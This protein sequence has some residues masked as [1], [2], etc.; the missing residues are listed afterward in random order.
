MSLLKDIVTYFTTNG[1]VT[2]E[3]VDAFMDFIPEMPD[4]IVS[5]TEYKGSPPV[6]YEELVHRSVQVL[7]RNKNADAARLKAWELYKLLKTEDE[8]GVV[9]FTSER[10]GQ[11]SLRQT[12]FR[13]DTDSSERVS[14]AFNMGVT[15]TID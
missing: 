13:V 3:G 15:T 7:V 14:Y 1:A 11:V 2:G 8:D 6:P 12:P 9:T 10:W 4:S 5:V